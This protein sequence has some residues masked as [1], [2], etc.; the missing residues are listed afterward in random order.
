MT[1][2]DKRDEL[3]TATY[4]GLPEEASPPEIDAAVLAAARQGIAPAHRR[5]WTVPVS[6]A[7]VLVL[8]VG[9]TVRMEHERP[10]VATME[11]PPPPAKSE[12]VPKV[13]R[14]SS[15]QPSA[16]TPPEARPGAP[17]E[18]A[19]RHAEP[20]PSIAPMAPPQMSRE[21]DRRQDRAKAQAEAPKEKRSNVQVA[22]NPAADAARSSSSNV[23]SLAAPPASAPR[24][25]V[26]E[27]SASREEQAPLTAPARATAATTAKSAAPD[28]GLVANSQEAPD[29]WLERIAVM[30]TQGRQI[31]ADV[32][33]AEFRRIY[34]KFNIPA[35]MRERI[36]RP[37]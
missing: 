20:A 24:A 1:D 2:E 8:A 29:V 26:Q 36:E 32:N 21:P 16:P 27:R 12:P 25:D 28:T 31:E 15:A 30:R 5:N 34:P 18:A 7:A 9:L 19:P 14:N 4:R 37:R 3:V 13:Q 35:Q 6:L 11:V 17:R 22:P 33:L 23:P 10:D